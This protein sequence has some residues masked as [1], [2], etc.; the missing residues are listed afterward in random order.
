MKN[1]YRPVSNKIPPIHTEKIWN[2]TTSV[3]SEF[4]AF[5]CVYRSIGPRECQFRFVNHCGKRYL[6]PLHMQ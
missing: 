5:R 6:R 3:L 4:F 1:G 2:V